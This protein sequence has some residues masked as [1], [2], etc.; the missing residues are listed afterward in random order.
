MGR[1]VFSIFYNSRYQSQSKDYA[2]FRKARKFERAHNFEANAYCE[3]A[4]Y[5]VTH[6]M[7]YYKG[8]ARYQQ[9]AK[10]FLILKDIRAIH[11]FQKSIDAF[12]KDRLFVYGYLCQ[13]E[14]PDGVNGEEFYKKAEEL[15]LKYKETHSCVI[16]QFDESE[17]DGNYEKALDHHQK[18]EVKT[19]KSRIID[20]H[21][22]MIT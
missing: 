9:A 19:L 5:A 22:L 8:V 10:C 12:L 3:A 20:H 14:F 7:P 1:N 21:N 4:E 16:T 13:R 11:C 15:S 6:K 2:L 18:S 17:Y